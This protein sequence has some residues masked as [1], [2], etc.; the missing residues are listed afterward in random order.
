MRLM[1]NEVT[2][3]DIRLRVLHPLAL[4]ESKVSSFFTL[5]QKHRQ[6]EKHMRLMAGA[7]PR[8]LKSL[9]KEGEPAS[10]ELLGCLERIM[11]LSLSPYGNMLAKNDYPLPQCFL[12]KIGTT[13]PRLKNWAT[14]RRPQW[15]RELEKRNLPLTRIFS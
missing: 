11:E 1:V 12:P 4:Y 8:Y 13:I 9:A 15:D 2:Y 3:Q 7:V 5:D 10:R 14:K 6:D